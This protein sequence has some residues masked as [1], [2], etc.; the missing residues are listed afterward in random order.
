MEICLVE[1]APITLRTDG[2]VDMKL[3]DVYSGYATRRKTGVY[4]RYIQKQSLYVVS[5]K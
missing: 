5:S 3:L 1:A 4:L 2:L